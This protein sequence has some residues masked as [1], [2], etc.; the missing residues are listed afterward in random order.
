MTRFRGMDD[1]PG[2][3]NRRFARIEREL[4]E[5]A[6]AKRLPNSSLPDDYTMTPV[7]P[8]PS[9]PMPLP[10][11]L[12][13]TAGTEVIKVVWSGSASGTIPTDFGRLAIHVSKLSGYTPTQGTEVATVSSPYGG[14]ALYSADGGDTY[15]VRCA[16]ASLRGD[17]GTFTNELAVTPGVAADAETFTGDVVGRSIAIAASSTGATSESFSGTAFPAGWSNYL[18]WDDLASVDPTASVVSSG[19]PAGSDNGSAIVVDYGPAGPGGGTLDTAAGLIV[20]DTDDA[21]NMDVLIRFAF[22]APPGSFPAEMLHLYARAAGGSSSTIPDGVYLDLYRQNPQVVARTGGTTSV[23]GTVSSHTVDSTAWRWARLRVIGSRVEASVWLD[24]EDEPDP[25]ITH[26]AT[27]LSPGGVQVWWQLADLVPAAGVDAFIDSL[28]VETFASG[29]T[30]ATDGTARIT[31]AEI[32]ELAL[33][34]A[35]AASSV[36]TLVSA[37]EVLDAAGVSLGWVPVYDTK[38]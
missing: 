22:T 17:Y 1:S 25:L 4:R 38:A 35:V 5:M 26:T 2:W 11:G 33:P 27:A 32:G 24:G 36:S 7:G 34:N 8:E 19:L 23:I 9:T 20:A 12:T 16:I 30:V 10:Q 37:F 28:D 21:V 13:I 29:F 14:T 6:S 3:I 18:Q 31:R 15:Y